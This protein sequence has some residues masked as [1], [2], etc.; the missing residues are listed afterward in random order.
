[1][2]D[3]HLAYLVSR[4]REEQDPSQRALLLRLLI[5]EVDRYGALVERLERL[6]RLIAEAESR[7]ATQEELSLLSQESSPFFETVLAN[8]RDALTNF[9]AYR[10]TLLGA[11]DRNR[12]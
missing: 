2:T 12:P 10:R 7:I 6:D 5:E 8:E 11:L 3:Q 1:M 9:Q 4:L